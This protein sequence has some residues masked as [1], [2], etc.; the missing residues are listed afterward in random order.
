LSATLVLWDTTTCRLA[1]EAGRTMIKNYSCPACLIF[2]NLLFLFLSKFLNF[3]CDIALIIE[4]QSSAITCDIALIIEEQ[5]SAITSI[6]S[7][8]L[9]SIF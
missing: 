2:C 7:H 8:S 4:E 9:G 5:S 6:F 3:T 1:S